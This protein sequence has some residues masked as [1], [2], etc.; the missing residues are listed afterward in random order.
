MEK[1]RIV[2]HC[3]NNIRIAGNGDK[4][5][6]MVRCSVSSSERIRSFVIKDLDKAEKMLLLPGFVSKLTAYL[7]EVFKVIFTLQLLSFLLLGLFLRH[8]KHLQPLLTWRNC[9]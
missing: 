2:V 8:T 9:V 6:T 4:T 5:V 7:W 3:K 1:C